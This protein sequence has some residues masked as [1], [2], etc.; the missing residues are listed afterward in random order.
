M[1]RSEVDVDEEPYDEMFD[2]GRTVVTNV[3]GGVPASAAAGARALGEVT[4]K[5]R[6]VTP[7]RDKAK[8]LARK[9]RQR[10]R[11]APLLRR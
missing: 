2:S 7:W 6:R 8:E 4:D 1:E 10:V 9:A 11:P 5:P 3:A